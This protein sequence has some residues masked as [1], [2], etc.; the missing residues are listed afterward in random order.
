MEGVSRQPSG[1]AGPIATH[2]AHGEV[3]GKG[4]VWAAQAARYRELARARADHRS[5][6]ADL[7]VR[8]IATQGPRGKDPV[9]DQRD[10]KILQGRATPD[11]LDT[12]ATAG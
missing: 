12:W 6:Y 1:P 7:L 2:R 9:W 8:A 3:H 4:R 11:E 10:Q 5:H